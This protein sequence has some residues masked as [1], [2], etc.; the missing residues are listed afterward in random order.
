MKIILLQDIKSLGKKGD[1]KDVAEGY[2]QN[3]L[4][5]KK[6]AGVATENTIKFF[7][8]QKEKEQKNKIAE[9]ERLRNLASTLKDK[10]ITIEAKEKKGKL[11]GSITV[12]NIK[13]ALEKEGLNILENSIIIKQAIKKVGEYEIEIKLSEEIREKIKLEVK[14]V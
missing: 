3:F 13:E 7:Q 12:K 1:V 10:K 2:A 5:P 8:S 4:L 9:T 14:G 6:L 11:F